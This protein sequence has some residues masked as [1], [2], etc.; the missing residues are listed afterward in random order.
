MS[1]FKDID[2]IIKWY[3][4]EAKPMNKERMQEIGEQCRQEWIA[5]QIH[6]AQQEEVELRELVRN[7]VVTSMDAGLY[8]DQDVFEQGLHNVTFDQS[9]HIT[10]LFNCEIERWKRLDGATLEVIAG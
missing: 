3:T 5:D 9:L 7:F 10:N 2:S 8:P 4:K 6:A 1:F